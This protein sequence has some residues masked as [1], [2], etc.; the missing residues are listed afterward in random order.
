MKKYFR[1]FQSARV[2]LQSKDAATGHRHDPVQS[3][4][5]RFIADSAGGVSIF[6]LV[7]FILII[8]ISGF[9]IDLMRHET[10][11]A[12]LQNALDRG[13][14]AAASLRQTRDAEEVV[15]DYLDARPFFSDQALEVSVTDQR[16]TGFNDIPPSQSST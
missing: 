13:V 2:L 12:D 16:T 8:L 10:E 5:S 6:M 1:T 14:L 15:R 4:T 9:A 7:F 11:R 3:L